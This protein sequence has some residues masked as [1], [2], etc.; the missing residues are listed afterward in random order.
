VLGES[1]TRAHLIGMVC[2]LVALGLAMV[3]PRTAL[4]GDVP[5]TGTARVQG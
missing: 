5:L 1:V 4:P 3:E 2:V